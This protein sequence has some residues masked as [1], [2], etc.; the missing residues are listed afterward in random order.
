MTKPSRHTYTVT[1]AA[2]LLGISRATAYECV[3][4]GEL[5]ALQLGRRILI[6]TAVLADLL[7]EAMIAGDARTEPGD[8]RHEVA[9]AG[10]GPDSAPVDGHPAAVLQDPSAAGPPSVT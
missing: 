7:G 8:L 3:R 6:P 10:P 5:P 4:T 1:E 9:T 2:A